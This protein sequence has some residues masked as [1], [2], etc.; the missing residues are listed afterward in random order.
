M[1]DAE[2]RLILFGMLT[3]RQFLELLLIGIAIGP[4]DSRMEA[5][6]FVALRGRDVGVSNPGE[7]SARKFFSSALQ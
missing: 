4:A 7:R 1:V 6:L 2:V 5:Y 3:V